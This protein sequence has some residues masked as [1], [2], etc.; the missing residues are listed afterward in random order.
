MDLTTMITS[1]R[2]VTLATF[3]EPATAGFI[4]NLLVAEGVQAFLADEF[5]MGTLWHLGN[6]IGWVK[7]QIAE[8]DMTR[9]IE[10]LESHREAVADLGY[11]AFTAEATSS[12]AADE[13]QETAPWTS[14]T[15][16]PDDCVAD[17]TEDLASRTL[18]SAVMG[19]GCVPLAFYGAWLVGRLILPTV[20][21]STTAARKLWLAFG[22]TIMVLLQ[23]SVIL[24][25]TA[26]L[27]AFAF[28]GIL[29]AS[30]CIREFI[31]WVNRRDDP[32]HASRPVS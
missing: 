26:L 8:T 15:D 30:F 25:S 11:E 9:A 2:L 29:V 1:N 23:Y 20:E 32:R 12:L 7:V 21:L 27:L 3:P 14:T 16:E 5:T 10:V 18:R 13:S 19:T 6:S 22:I 4:K 17:P 28:G 31:R 24:G